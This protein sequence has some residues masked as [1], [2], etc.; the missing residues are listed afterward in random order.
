MPRHSAQ[1]S[2]GEAPGK[3][4]QKYD[5]KS[6]KDRSRWDGDD[7]SDYIEH[8]KPD[9]YRSVHLVFRFNSP[10]EHRNC[11]QGQRIEIQIR[12]WLQHLWATAVETAQVFT[13]QALKSKIKRANDD[14]LRFFALIS[15]AFA[16][17]E[18]R[19][20]VPCT[21]ADRGELIAELK[22]VIERENI[23]R[24]IWG[25]ANTIR[26]VAEW[27]FPSD[28]DLYLLRLDPN[29]RTLDTWAYSKEKLADAQ[30]DYEQK[31]KETENDPSV[32]IVLVSVDD[33]EA[34]KKAYPN[35]FVDI[36][37]FL[38]AVNSEIGEP[39]VEAGE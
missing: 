2:T 21:P 3:A 14:W 9:G 23:L 20:L 29:Q 17:R 16:M 36:D 25:W 34:L 8:P 18:K 1:C 5:A 35:Y 19:P 28:S 27:E 30:R 24:C 26:M 6:P 15:S 33:F 10:S 37:A 31:E 4:I 38:A 22:A 32:Q 39:V 11:Y 7:R 12:S 13:G